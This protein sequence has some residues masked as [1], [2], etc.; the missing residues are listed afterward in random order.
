MKLLAPAKINLFLE[1]VDK[2]IDGYHNIRTIFQKIE[3]FDELSFEEEDNGILLTVEGASLPTGHENIVYKA[4]KGIMDY[5]NIKKGIRIHIKKNIPVGAGLGGGSSDAAAALLGACS[6]WN[7]SITLNELLV[8][9]ADLGAD[10]PFFLHGASA[11]GL[12][13][14]D[15]L[16][17][18][19]LPWQMRLLIVNPC[20]EISTASVYEKYDSLNNN[21]KMLLT[22]DEK[23]IKIKCFM[24][25]ETSVE[26]IGGFLYNDLEAVVLRDYP[27]VRE[28]KAE[29]IKQGAAGSLMT[30]S[31]P[32][33]FGVFLDEKEA[34][35]GASE[36]EKRGYKVWVAKT[37]RDNKIEG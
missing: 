9:A 24:H 15:E 2:R 3:L 22:K 11:L 35:K 20:I 18:I 34:V 32:T 26:N 33:V 14:G 4:V 29:L 5:A 1:V 6:L 8:I 30:G 23:D 17:P 36:F 25:S 16:Y 31:G 21:A 37:L 12:G 27:V 13:R 28:L 10:V 19:N 7:I